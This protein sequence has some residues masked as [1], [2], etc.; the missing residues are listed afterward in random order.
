MGDKDTVAKTNAPPN[1][2]KGGVAGTKG[3][4]DEWRSHAGVSPF[5]NKRPPNPLKGGVAGAKGKS[6]ERRSHASVSP[7]NYQLYRVATL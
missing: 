5:K 2:L 6:D 4:S 3:K 7:F 1:P